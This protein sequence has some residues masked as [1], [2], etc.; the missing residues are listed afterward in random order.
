MSVPLTYKFAGSWSLGLFHSKPSISLK[1]GRRVQANVIQTIVKAI[2]VEGIV[3][4]ITLGTFVPPGNNLHETLQ[5]INV[6][7]LHKNHDIFRLFF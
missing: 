5:E 6:Y 4:F 2:K 3:S 7:P 1:T